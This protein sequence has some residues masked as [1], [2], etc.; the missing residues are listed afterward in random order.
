MP[1]SPA[2]SDSIT[3]DQADLFS[4]PG[5]APLTEQFRCLSQQVADFIV[6]Q[7][8]ATMRAAE[9]DQL[10]ETRL[11][12]YQQSVDQQFRDMQLVM[13]ELQ[14]LMTSVGVA[15]FRVAAEELL[16]MGQTHL[17]K[18]QTEVEA[19]RGIADQSSQQ[20]Q[21]ISQ[22]ADARVS[23]LVR[24]VRLDYFKTIVDEGCT[25]VETK[26]TTMMD[27]LKQMTHW[28][29]WQSLAIALG[30]GLMITLVM[31]YF[32]SDRMPW[33]SHKMIASERSAG[34]ALIAAWPKLSDKER[35]D[36]RRYG[37]A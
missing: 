7:E 4:L 25:R 8:N 13:N 29:Q 6:L 31:G 2:A 18:M 19:F 11:A 14:E 1:Q 3:I 32:I 15:R 16:T 33:E 36:I 12:S 22:K 35:T 20:L 30:T 9:Q 21:T 5:N 37:Q 26:Q 10:R 24:G 23:N 27:K 28:F 17:E 34:H